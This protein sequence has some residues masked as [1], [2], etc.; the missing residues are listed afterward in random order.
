MTPARP[1]LVVLTG[2]TGTGKSALAL[3]LV[4][5]LAS[6]V[7][8]E[9]ISVDSAQVYRGMDIG[10]AKP[11]PEV[12]TRIAHHLIDIRNPDQSYSAGDFVRDAGVAISACIQRGHLPLLVGGTMLYLRALYDGLAPLPAASPAV[13]RELDAEAAVRGWPA[14]HAEL[15]AIDPRAAAH[16]ERNDGQ[17]IQRALEVHRLT[18]VPITQWQRQ[19]QGTREQFRWLRYALLPASRELLRQ[20]LMARFECMLQAGLLE[21]VRQLLERWQLSEQHPAMRA[22]GYRQLLRFLRHQCTLAEASQQAL[23]ATLQLAKRQ[24]TWLRRESGMTPLIAHDVG[25]SV[26]L[27]SAVRAALAHVTDF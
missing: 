18:G 15:A 27:E 16:I 26:E 20:Q 4:E 7:T 25:Q 8:V 17:R 19:R 23:I 24:M 13:R 12:R 21:E 6:R 11:A 3:D 2:P 14:L 9:I 22:V 1:L 5:R 10:T